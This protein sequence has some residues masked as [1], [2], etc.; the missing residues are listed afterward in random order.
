MKTKCASKVTVLFQDTFAMPLKY[1]THVK[2][3]IYKLGF[4]VSKLGL[5]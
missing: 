4:Q 3:E 5:W 2:L 1:V